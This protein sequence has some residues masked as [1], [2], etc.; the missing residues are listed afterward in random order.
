MKGDFLQKFVSKSLNLHFMINS[1]KLQLSFL[2]IILFLT[3]NVNAQNFE[4]VSITS[5]SS[6]TVVDAYFNATSPTIPSLSYVRVQKV[7][8]AGN[9]GEIGY[10][11]AV[12]NFFYS[13]PSNSG[14]TAPSRIRISFIASDKVTLIPVNDFR[15]IIND[16][17]GTPAAANP[18]IPIENEAVGTDCDNSVR[19]TATD[20]PTNI[21]VDTTPPTLLSAGTESEA[22]GPESNLMFEFND[23]N[24]I[25]FDIY[26][27]PGFIKEFDLNQSE[28]QINTVLYSVCV[29]DSDG[30]G[31]FDN[32][33]IDDDNDG[34]LDIVE[35]NGNDPNGDADGDGLPNF[36]DVLDNSGDGVPTYNANA[37]GSVTNYTDANS[38]GVPDV[39]EASQ[40]N[41]SYPNHLDL[42]SDDDGIPDNIEAQ[43]SGS[44]IAPSGNDSDGDGLDDNYEGSG[45]QGLIPVNTDV[46]FA[47]PD[48]VPDF[49]D[50]DS[51]NDGIS[52]AVEAYDTNG[53]DVAETTLAGN[54]T[55]LDGIDDNFDQNANGMDDP[56]A[57]TNNGQTPNSFQDDDPAGG[58][59]DWRDPRDSDGDGTSDNDD[60]DDDNDGIVDLDEYP[61]LDPFGDEDGDGIL[62]FKD[63]SQDVGNTGDGT[64]TNYNDADGN[65]VP[66]AYDV[67]NDGQPNHL[68]IDSDDDGH[69][70]ATDPNPYAPTAQDENVNATLGVATNINILSNDDYFPNNNPNNQ[71]TTTITRTGGTAGG[72]AILDAL[73]GELAYTPLLTENGST[74]TVI[75]QV[76]NTD[77]DPDVCETATVNITVTN[78]P[79]TDG[80]GTPDSSD[81]DDDNDGVLDGDDN[82][83][84]DPSSCQ[85]LDGDGCDDCSATASNDFTVGDNFDPA[86]DGTD[87]DGDGL[88]DASDP[89]DDNDGVLDGDDNAP[90]DPSSC[91]DL[92][93][94]GCDDC[95]ATASTDFS[96]GNNFDPANDGTDTDGDGICDSGDTDDDND[97]VLDGND[98][99]PLDP[100]SCQDLDNDGCDDCSA[101][102]SNDFTGGNN[103]DPANDG[104]DT[105]GDGLCDSG[106]ADDDNDG[107]LDGNDNAPLDPSSCQDLDGDGCDDCSATA[108][109]D[110]SV[111]NNFDTDNDGTDTDGDGICDSGDAD[112]DNDGVLDGDDNAPIDPSSCQDLDGDGC[113]DCSAT[114]NND[115]SVGNNFDASNDGIDTDG[116]GVCD[117]GDPDDDNDG[118]LDGDD[119]AP[120]DPS[121][122]QDLDGDG[123]DDCSATAST[124]F[125]AGSNFDPAN[126]GT[127]TDGDGICDSGDTDDDNDGVL[128]VNDNAPLDP[129]SCQDLDGDGC[130]DCSA[131]ASTDF[132]A[133]NNFDP[134][135]DG[136]DTDGDGICDA[137]DP[138]DDNDGVADGSDAAPL[139]PSVCQDLDGDG[140]DDCSATASTDFSAGNNFD[141]SNDGTD[142]DGDGICDDSDPDDDND[143]VLDGDDNAPLDPSSCQDLDG[144]GCDDCSATAST[145]FTAG[146]NFDTDT[147]GT[148]TDG[149]GICDASDPDDD[150]DGVAD[151]SD[152]APLDPSICQDLDSDGCDD[153]SATASNDFTAGANFDTD[154]DGTDTDG[155]GICDSSDLD[156]DNDGVADGSDAAPLDPS[157]CQDLDGDGCDDCSATASTDFSAGD[158]YDPSNDGTDTDGDGLCDSGDPDDDN[159]GVPDGTDTAPLDPSVCQDS[160]GDGC[161][162]CSATANNDFTAGVNFDPANDGTDTDGDGLCDS[163]DPDDDNDGVADGSDTDPLDPSICQ[164]LDGDG[165]DDCGAT[166]SNDF[167]AGANFDP[168]NDGIDT[169]GDGI[170]NTNDEDDDN[171]GIL[172]TVEGTSDFDN[173]GIPNNEDLDSDN[174][175]IPDVVE[176]GNGSLDIDGNGSIDPSE[177]DPGTNGIPNSAEDGGVDGNGVTAVP[178]N[179]DNTGGANYLDIDSDNDGIQDLVESQT[180]AGLVQLS[181]N[182][183][184][185]DGI[186]D[187]FDADNG[188]SFTNTLVNT[189]SDSHP[190]Y[191][192]LDSDDDGIID[193]IEWQSTSGYL[194]PSADSDGNG[195]ADN[196]EV[197]PAGSGESINQPENSDGQDSPDF[198]DLDSDNDGVSDYVEAYDTDADNTADTP[199]SGVDSDND[200]LD[201]NFDLSISAPNGIADANGATNNNQDVDNFPNDQDPFTS[202]VDFRDANVHLTPIDTDGDGVNNDLDKDND[203]DDILDYVESLGFEPTDTKGDECG[204]PPGSFTGGSYIAATGSGAGTVGAEYR[205][206][207]VVTSSLGV[208]DA[209][210]AITDINNATLTSIDN[211]GFGSDDAWQPSFDVGG[212]V[213]AVGSITFNIRLVATGTDFQVNLIRFGGV[214]YD[215]DGANTE[216]SVTLAQ[217]GLYAVDS[218]TLLNIS[219]NAATGTTTFE[220]PAQTWSGVDFGPKLAVY[221]NYYD[222]TNFT[223]TFSGELQSGFSSNDYLGSILFQ[224]CDINGLFTPTNTTSAVNSAGTPSGETSGPGTAP[225]YT[226]NEGID[227]DNDGIE[228]HLDID[229]DND[230]IPDNVEAQ[231]TSGYVARNANTDGNGNDDT[232][233]DGL[234][235]EYEGTGDEGVSPIDT[236]GDGIPDY[237]DLDTDGDGL[238]DTEEAGFTAASNNLDNDHDGLFDDYDDVD[239]TGLPFDSNDDQDNGASDLP[240]IAVTTTTEVDYR[241]NAIDDNDLDGI[242]DSADLDDDNDGILDTLE[243]P[244]GIDPSADD[245]S[246][247][248]L[249]YRDTDLGVD[250]NGDGIVD[251]FDTDDDGV[252][253]H[254]DLDADNDGIYDIVESGSGQAFTDGLL[255]GDVGTDGIPD[256][257]QASGQQDSGTVNYTVLDSETTP[258]GIADFLELDADGDLCNDV[259]EAGFTDD[260]GDGILG[261]GALV[262]DADGVVTGTNVVDGYTEPNN[263]DSTTNTDFDFQQLGET[264]TIASSTDQPQDVL[265]NA[266][267]SETFTVTASGISLAYQWEVDDQLGGGFVA[268]DDANGTDIYTGSTTETLTLTGATATENGFEYRVIITD[269]TFVCSPLTSDAALLTIDVTAP[270]VAI[271]VVS[272]DDIINAIEDDSDVTISGTTTGA[273]NGQIVTVVLNGHTYTTTV[274][275]GVWSLDVPAVDVQALNETESI[276]ADVSDLAGNPAVQATRDIVHD[277]TAP[278][279]TINVVSTDDIISGFEDD[280]DVTISGTTTGAEDGQTVTVVLNGETYTTTVTSDAWTL[281]MPATDAQALDPSETITADVSDLA[282]NPATQAT[283]D[284]THDVT[285][286]TIA[287]NVVAIDDVINALED[288]TD[289]TINGTTDAED[290]QTVTVVLNGEIYTT[291]VTSGTWTLD[292]P[293]AE[294]QVLDA[295]ETI[296]A[297]V[298]DV[299]GNPATQAT[300]DI[301]H[302]VT[303]PIITINVVATDDIINAVEDDDDVTINGTTTDV[304]DG[305]TVTVTLN[306]QTYTTTV[307]GGSWSFDLPAADAQAL[308]TTRTIT[309]DVSNDAGNPAVQATRDV[310]HDA[311]AP[312]IAINVVSTDDIIN[313][314]ED[315]TDVTISGS[316]TGAEDGQTVTVVLN[317][318]TYTTTVAGGTWSFDLPAAAAQ[319]LDALETITADVSDVAGNPATQAARDIEHDVA[320]PTITIDV[321][322]GDDVINAVEDDTDV[323]IS[324]TTTDAENGQTV[325]VLLD[326]QT[327]TTTVTGG[328]WSFDLPAAAAQALGATET[329]TADVSDVAGNP[330]IQAT[331]D[332]QHDVTAPTITID[333]VTT[334]DIINAV[335]DDTDVTISGTTTDA[336]DGQAVTVTLHGQAYTTTV[337]GGT[338]SFDL[339]AAAAQA[340]GA[341]ETITADV[342]DAAGNPATQATRV[343][344]HDVTAPTVA[345]DVVSTDDIINAIEDDTDVTI[346]GT[347]TGAEDGQTVTVELNGQTYTTTVTG[348]IWSFDLPA[349]DSQALGATETITADVSDLAGNPAIQSSRDIEHDVTAPTITIDVVTGD[350]VI[351]AVEDDTDVTISGTTTGAEDGQTVTVFLDG[352]TYTTTVTGGIWSIDLPAAAAQALG[353]SETITAD[354]S[355]LAG[356][357]ATQATRDIEH[358][359]TAP[360][361]AI[362]VVSGDDIISAVEDDT[363]VTISGTTTGAEDGQTVTIV[364][365]GQ[366]YTTT[367]TGGTWSFDLPAADAQALNPLET[368]TADVSDLAG[369][370]A[371]QATRDIIHDDTAPV[372]T[373]DVV[374]TDDIINEFEQNSDVTI[375]GTADAEDGQTATV[376]LNGQTYTTTVIGGTWSLDVPAVDVQALDPNETITADVSDLAGNTATQATRDIEHDV[377]APVITIDVV[378]LD[379]VI[380]S[381]EDDSDIIISG[382]TDAEDGQIV[383]VLLDGQT[384]TTT[385]T[386]GTW[387]FDLPEAAAQALDATETITADVSDL[388][389]NPATQATRDVEHDVTAPIIAINVVSTDDIINAVEDDSDVAIN[390][391][392]DAEDGQTVTVVLHGQ[393][394]T[395]TVTGGI[396]SLDV[397]ATDAQALNANE[398]ITANVNDVSGNPAVEATRDIEHDV[399]APTISINVVSTDDIINAVEDDSDVTINGITDAEDG[400]IVTVTLNGQT[401]TTLVTGGT[402][403]LEVPAADAQA[404]VA[405]ETITADVSNVAGNPAIQATRGIEHDVTPPIITIDV[406]SNDDVI[407]GVEDDNDV[408]ISGTTD[409]E[410]GQTVTVTLNGQ[411]YTTTVIGGIWSLDVPAADAQA[412][413]VNETITADVSD[414][415][416]NPATQDAR[417]IVHDVIIDIEIN[418]PIE[419]DNIVSEAEVADVIISGVTTGVEDNQTVTVTLD[420][421]VNSV[422]T[423]ATVTAGTWTANEIDISGLNN[424]PISVNAEVSDFA[425]NTADD[426]ESIVLNTTAPSADSFSTSDVTPIVTGQGDANESLVVEL[427][428]NGDNIVDV[429]YSVTVDLNGDWS[430]DTGSATP[431]SGSLP[432]LSDE[433]VIQVIVT[434]ETGNLGTG[435][436]TISEDTDND[437]LTNNEEVALGTDP[438]DPDS[439]GDGINDGQEVNVDTTDPLDDCDHVGGTPLGTSDCDDDGLST[440]EE[441]ALGTDTNNPDTDNDGLT[442]GEE[443]D[444]GTDPLNPDSDGDGIN[445]GQEVLDNTDP[446][447]D[448]DHVGGTAFP[449]SDCDAD[450][451]N[452]AQEDAIGTDPDVADTDGDTISDGQEII[453]GTDPLNPCDSLN[454]FPPFDAGCN[455][456]IVD[457]GIAVANEV[458]TPDGDGTNDFFGIENIES[459]PNNTV[460][461]YNRWGILVYEMSGY[462]NRT[463]VFTGSSDGRATLSKDSELPVG[464]YFYVIKYDNDGNK[465]NKSGY[466]YINR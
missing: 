134:S 162:D 219:E 209:I 285:A 381:I 288:D 188:G 33:D 182:D 330:A 238:S 350:D 5:I 146:A 129:S 183:S 88:C 428:T 373:I 86:N 376:T 133:G 293:A 273:E 214:I 70:D 22:N 117:S 141:P 328:T 106:D 110:F 359:V 208:L 193:N 93:N 28:Y 2:A 45:N 149:D 253:N 295:L 313:A 142:T 55:D 64:T 405:N 268:I 205:F 380:N 231:T 432:A 417:D 98:N 7:S 222:T 171:D 225:V 415:A 196:Y 389:G 181:G 247:G 337:T 395:T 176:T 455:A 289:V 41:D 394:Y 364:L 121:S 267:F 92:D 346:S 427:D 161:D 307:S 113:D 165:C 68:D 77:P 172:D 30:D 342:S 401:Y 296:T 10:S 148:D 390:G 348:G 63:T 400:Q 116:D 177:S 100:S 112:D 160:D 377:T 392:T 435:T 50:P 454:G 229:S 35:S 451:L 163:G 407:N 248:I 69:L 201:D 65:G 139:D 16:I 179:S 61:G 449:D 143:G 145:D 409:A 155:D 198:R 441:T 51:D 237:L 210:V 384:Y 466:L 123:C 243:S 48:N 274:T 256:S 56:D 302:D 4:N 260:N 446:L 456:E 340:L 140:C 287:I 321:V 211:G 217:P 31:V 18:S 38:D 245:D 122:C 452:T 329:I 227:S 12:D 433:D 220:G 212:G 252:P 450:G 424:G 226:I 269:L 327:Y 403:S 132:S 250:A 460:Q 114:A 60:T 361:I 266:S 241:E 67:D 309:A 224:T 461:I 399:T 244:S 135:N 306:G 90:L 301:E 52:D 158:N 124:D 343:V 1:S 154:N 186:D 104:I 255:D 216:E 174:D 391:T 335:E 366:T 332:I 281:D 357:P 292:V 430:I 272:T 130:D 42:D 447:D 119:N 169:D 422:T 402:W 344:T 44:Y 393:T 53:D 82:A 180:D 136:T 234:G 26:A 414:L 66:D 8:G 150:N 418:T 311:I 305:Q 178:V 115:F 95:S 204:I 83:P 21:N 339:P 138:D 230:G 19:F 355:D 257:V 46:A 320:A 206:S 102:A 228:D 166:A 78:D 341:T 54:D 218:N 408:T 36:Q 271:D 264:P 213:G 406:V 74:V 440:D 108:N 131:T 421:G 437:G 434:D 9:N 443:V 97:G 159:D 203:N 79:D 71:G 300:R 318:Q 358:D 242:A 270:T 84:F 194:S 39:Y 423:T 144:D 3:A 192:D 232:D 47:T 338:W 379:D 349:A 436:V 263:V 111:G 312:T 34:I 207:T 410:D 464:V 398:T 43:A 277:D 360:T 445:D 326:G 185:N 325:S 80:D 199:I 387:S 275:G 317:G 170:C 303:V 370:L 168:D 279:I 304:E 411:T 444:L 261:D 354:V 333:V 40:D 167:T 6:G 15:I 190:D 319:A 294:A 278:T 397:P 419:I 94:D 365:N 49:L 32:V 23:V 103:F 331:R 128:D 356:N 215:I 235:D 383:T 13:N 431:D 57:A 291:T 105:D 396:W 14:T 258:D 37:D 404:L 157:I 251:D 388:A 73:T 420:D 125:S 429:T 173:D 85:D 353:A 24:F 465:L 442:D 426:L 457:S 347:T 29:G 280:S 223:V 259:I 299:A 438:N 184:D 385:V 221:F 298:S 197:V 200:G 151:G 297:D 109:T 107:V 156:D 153:C 127:D 416:G 262:V 351:N 72:T 202:E 282:G 367:V 322:S 371:T 96:A 336:E 386:G 425:G 87:T 352:Q 91:Q 246:D 459:F 310:E 308:G 463:N 147:D 413:D 363:D 362:D 254:F 25:E 314:L 368:I 290:G 316:T 101:T 448:C 233:G 315:D 164:D 323:T 286:P 99:A 76:C 195:L 382:T 378:A 345:I 20:I 187:V 265:T 239:T 59:R 453:D 249:N 374:S 276:T 58:E 126:D 283:R 369:N 62:N 324:G 462:D 27:N 334:D 240:N 375:S 439:D 236:D 120:L 372:I 81:A 191:L 458:I 17:D 11:S 412:L 284:I 118:V 189:D 152:A 89:D 137:S 175:G 75:Y